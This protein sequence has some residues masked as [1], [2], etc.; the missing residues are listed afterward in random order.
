MMAE[1][2]GESKNDASDTYNTNSKSADSFARDREAVGPSGEARGDEE[3]Q[4]GPAGQESS[5][6]SPGASAAQ[7]VQAGMG[8]DCGAHPERP[9]HAVCMPVLSEVAPRSGTRSGIQEDAA[10]AMEP[11]APRGGIGKRWHAH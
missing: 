4:T 6:G 5:C 10:R 11:P 1:R 8:G 9:G 7:I 2:P 3:R